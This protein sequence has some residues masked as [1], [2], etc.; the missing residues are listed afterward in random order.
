MT[1]EYEDEVIVTLHDLPTSVNAALSI[2]HDGNPCIPLNARLTHEA[3][4]KAY[5][6][7]MRH[8]R[9][10]DMYSGIRIDLAEHQ[11]D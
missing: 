8:L 1:P 7:E 11:A 3:Q 9:R 5:Q 10:N 4:V 6:H 2:D